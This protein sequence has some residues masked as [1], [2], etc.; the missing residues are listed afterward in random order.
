M[1]EAIDDMYAFTNLTDSVIG[2]IRSTPSE[3]LEE[4]CCFYIGKKKL[5]FFISFNRIQHDRKNIPP[6]LL[7][8]LW[9]HQFRP[10][11]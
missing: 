10:L 7:L 3:D 4:V 8:L 2:R 6:F 9:K 11:L 5:C 1:S